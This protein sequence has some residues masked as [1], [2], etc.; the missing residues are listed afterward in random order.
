[1]RI[2]LISAALFIFATPVAAH[3]NRPPIQVSVDPTDLIGCDTTQAD[4]SQGDTRYRCEGGAYLRV[5]GNGRIKT[6]VRHEEELPA[7]TP[8]RAMVSAQPAVIPPGCVRITDAKH[9]DWYSTCK[10]VAGGRVVSWLMRDTSGRE[11]PGASIA[12]TR[13][14]PSDSSTSSDDCGRHLS[15]RPSQEVAYRE[16][17]QTGCVAYREKSRLGEILATGVVLGVI[18]GLSDGYYRRGGYDRGYGYYPSTR[19]RYYGNQSMGRIGDP[20]P[21]GGGQRVP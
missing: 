2:I 7:A 16:G 6:L 8:M 15:G 18:D 11:I 10:V 4:T 20:L 14:Q 12:E 3:A 9:S 17:N 21:G 13:P 1:M 5:E 19:G